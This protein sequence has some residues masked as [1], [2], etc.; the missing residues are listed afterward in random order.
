MWQELS[1]IDKYWIGLLGVVLLFW[2]ISTVFKGPIN[3]W[4]GIKDSSARRRN[5]R[6]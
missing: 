5:R 2:I 3:R 4:L 1:P 6:H